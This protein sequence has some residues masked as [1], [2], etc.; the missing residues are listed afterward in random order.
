MAANG[1]VHPCPVLT[2]PV[3]NVR[4]TE[5]ADLAAQLARIYEEA[6]VDHLAEC[7][8]CDLRLICGGGCR[9][10]N[11]RE[12]GDPCRPSC[13]EESRQALYRQLVALENRAA[14]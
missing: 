12:Q 13:T 1:D 8:S 9:V 14:T 4:A 5:L 3:G 7:A 6:S 10:R 2:Q 11:L